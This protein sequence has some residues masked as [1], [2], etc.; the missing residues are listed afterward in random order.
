MTRQSKC[1]ALLLVAL[2]AGAAG[3]PARN[4]RGAA[5]TATDGGPQG[6]PEPDFTLK[7]VDLCKEYEADPAAAEAKYRGKWLLVEGEV[8]PN[9][10]RP[11][12]MMGLSV[13]LGQYKPDAD[14][15]G[16]SVRADMA[17]GWEAKAQ[18]LSD[19]QRVKIKGKCQG[20]AGLWVDLIQCEL[21]EAG[22]DPAVAVTAAQLSRDGL[23][24][25]AAAKKYEGKSLR[26]EGTVV[27]VLRNPGGVPDEVVLEGSEETA[28]PVR[29]H[30]SYHRAWQRHFEGLRKGQKVTLKASRVGIADGKVSLDGARLMP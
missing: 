23:D 8:N 17:S 3:C 5:G 12:F 29:V 26:V 25:G 27:E 7:A 30:A 14:K 2:V 20:D 15:S 9:G 28:A 22:A 1:G 21:V 24:A 13:E 16:R 11:G 4:P 18:A 19:R 10:V 6:S